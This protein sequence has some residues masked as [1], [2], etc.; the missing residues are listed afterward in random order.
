MQ[1]VTLWNALSAPYSI[2]FHIAMFFVMNE[3]RYPR[4][5]AAAY[6]VIFNLP[7]LAITIVMYMLLGSERGGQLALLFYLVPQ[8]AVNF[9]L[10]RY[11]DGRL[12]SVY[13]KMLFSSVDEGVAQNVH[14][15]LGEAA[16][17]A[18]AV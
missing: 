13:F 12:F 8:L 16:G 3:Y 11:R 5:K 14:Q 17:A 6:T 2:L 10:S 9:F 4:K 7:I 1:H 15:H 18:L